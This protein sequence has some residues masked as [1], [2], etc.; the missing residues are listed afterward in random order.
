VGKHPRNDG[1][2]ARPT[3]SILVPTLGRRRPRLVDALAS[4][5]RQI[6][7]GDELIVV[8]TDVND[9][10]NTGRQHAQDKATG[11]H[12]LYCDDDDVFLAGALDT[13]RRWA[14]EN[15]GKIG[16][17]RRRFNASIAPQWRDPVLRPGNVQS[18]GFCIPNVPGKV[19]CWGR[20]SR[21]PD[22]AR[23]LREEGVRVWSD[24][25]FIE[26]SARL[27]NAEI[28]FVDEVV[29]LARPEKNPLR[30]LR[31]RLALGTRLRRA[32]GR[33]LDDHRK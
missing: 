7:P 30:R 23:R 10:G 31:Y 11:S 2:A 26:E 28:V 33:P 4:I 20:K 22:V 8:A 14:A 32:L 19:G 6:E 16:V 24:I 15:P 3:F 18:M 12:L 29:G 17:F 27:Q 9:D 1:D 13:F 25:Y 21:D 5:A